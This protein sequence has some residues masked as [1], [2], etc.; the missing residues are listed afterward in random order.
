[1]ELRRVLPSASFVGSSQIRVSGA[2]CH[3]QDV[4][5]GVLFAA[6]P[7]T[8]GDGQRFITEAIQRGAVAVLVRTP[9]P[10]VTVPQC[11]VPDVRRA[12]AQVC[13][14]AAGH[15]AQTLKTVGITGTNGKT[16]TTWL[17]R[18]LLA[19]AGLRCGLLGTVEYHD[20]VQGQTASLTTPD[21]SVLSTWLARMVRAGTTHVAL[22]AS[23]HALDQDRISATGLDVAAITN[24]TQDHFDYHGDFGAYCSV[25]E[26]IWSHIK[27]GGIGIVNLDDPAS[28]ASRGSRTDV[29]FVTVSCEHR[30][31]DIRAE[32]IHTTLFGTAFE[33]HLPHGSALVTSPLVGLHNVSNCLVAATAAWH[34]GLTAEQIAH[35]LS[36][37][38]LVPGRL[39]RIECGQS[40][41]VFVDYAHTDDA[42]RRCVQGLKQLTP[43]RVL[44]LYGAGGDRDRTK[45]PLLTQAAQTADFAM[46][47][48]DNPRTEDPQSII[49]DCLAGASP[50]LPAPVAV[51]DRREAIREILSLARPG[52]SVLIA[53][54]GHETEQIIGH[55]RHHF[56]DVEE[57][58]FCLT[59]CPPAWQSARTVEH[60]PA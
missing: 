58:R 43:G 42:L 14:A 15:P 49:R 45:R 9:L 37:P 13:S 8:T 51:V 52:D 36:R 39:Q 53:G 11:V 28:A 54:K 47:T 57:V 6:I 32:V 35:G 21:A 60:V 50:T 31:A 10:G 46:L 38:L 19:N 44:V 29:N 48:S 59:H 34:L 16:T 17:V 40:F 3:T 4:R 7:G 30:P 55:E 1:M 23:S 33:L 27:P 56:D 25:K 5:P 41:A 24:I 12:Y 18:G 22:E 2:V 20:G 26:R